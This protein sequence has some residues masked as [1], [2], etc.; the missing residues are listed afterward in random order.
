M[1]HAHGYAAR[2]ADLPLAPFAFERREPGP[3]DV[4]IDILYCGVCHSDLHTA[5]NEW[6]NT[7]YPS[8]PGHEIVG[9]VT[10]VGSAVDGF[11]VGDIAGVGCMVDSCRQCASCKEGQEQYCEAGFTGTYNGPMFGGENTYGGYSDHVVVDEK[12]VLHVR[13]AEADLAAVAPLL[14]AGITTYS[15][16]AHWK[17]GPGQKVGVVGL[18]GLGHMGVKIAKAMGAEVVLFTTSESKRADALRL[19]A[20]AVVISKDPAQMAAQANSLD[21]I[22]N[23]V[24][25]RHDL[26][27]FLNA[28]K[29]DGAMVLVGAPEHPHPAPTVFNL[30]MK[31]RTLAGSLIGGIRETQDMLDFCAKHGIVADIEMIRMDQVE[32][33]YARMLKGDVKYRFVIDMATLDKAA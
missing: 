2:S 18:G 30:I 7:L 15:P 3:H 26:D 29:R 25:A 4:R 22:L 33:G 24:A 12:Y 5:R 8:V 21:F 27:P 9:R 28:L 32:Q 11:K 1:S 16:L 31:R 20:D 13:H 17:V 6:Q 14:C 19:G 10:A 23:T